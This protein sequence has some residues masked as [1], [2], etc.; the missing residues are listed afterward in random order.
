MSGRRDQGQ[1]GLSRRAVAMALAF[2]GVART[3]RASTIVSGVAPE[4]LRTPALPTA[5]ARDAAMLA[6]A[7]AG[8]RLVAAGERGIVLFSDDG[9]HAWTQARVPAQVSLT[10]LRFIDE[11][12]GWAVGHLGAILRSDDA[13]ARWALQLDGVRAARIQLDAASAGGDETAIA[14]AR[15]LVED[16]PDKAFFDVDFADR[17]NGIAVGAYGMAFATRDGGVRWEPLTTRLPN[18]KG[19]HL[20]GVRFAGDAVFI[21]GEQGLLLRSTDGGASYAALASPYKGSLFGLIASRGLLIAYGL[22]GNAFRSVD[23]GESWTPIDTGVPVS[24]SAGVDLGADGMVLL[25]Q[26]SD[27]LVS[28]DGGQ[29][30]RRT[31]ARE[32]TPATAVVANARGELVIAGLRGLRAPIAPPPSA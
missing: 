18:P 5:R 22:R 8:D 30:F 25:C 26:T 23:Q 20:Y 29:R 12:S 32:P 15:K 11:R 14:R 24:L 21:V 9:G 31:P 3:A 6:L 17:Q 19:L 4:V 1:R 13:G 27:V 10:A 28:R 2:G 7:R 16:G